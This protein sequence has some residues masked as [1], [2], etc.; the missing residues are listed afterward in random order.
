MKAAGL[1]SILQCRNNRLASVSG[2]RAGIKYMKIGKKLLIIEDEVLMSKIL[3]E[4][5]AKDG[6]QVLQAGDG[7]AGLDSA[8]A[9]KPDIILLDIVM[10]KIDGLAVMEKIRASGDWGKKVPIIILTNL[11]IEKEAITK[12]MANPPAYYMVKTDWTVDRVAE[13]AY[14]LLGV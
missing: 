3:S 9:K 4:R 6:L 2:D 1:L 7:Q 14:E 5:F 12:I 10:P 8:L 13:K 11:N